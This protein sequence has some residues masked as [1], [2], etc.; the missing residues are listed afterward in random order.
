MEEIT[1]RKGGGVLVIIRAEEALREE[2]AYIK[3]NDS[4][5]ILHIILQDMNYMMLITFIF[6]LPF[7]FT[8]RFANI[9]SKIN[10]EINV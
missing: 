4:R 6:T 1:S 7:I 8:L 10:D 9:Y 3:T 2:C 5:K